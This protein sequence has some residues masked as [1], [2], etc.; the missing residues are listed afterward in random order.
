VTASTD[1]LPAAWRTLLDVASCPACRSPLRGAWCPA[2]GLR[3]DGPRG[4][5]LWQESQEAAAALERRAATLA[6]LVTA[7]DDAARVWAASV[8]PAA[9]QQ[10]PVQEWTIQ[11]APVQQAPVQRAAVRPGGVPAGPGAQGPAGY[12]SVPGPWLGAGSPLPVPFSPSTRRPWRVQTILQVLGAGLLAAASIVFLVFAWDVL[13]LVARAAVVGVGT[14]A[15]LVLAWWL[16]RRGLVQGAEA[17]GGFGVVLVLLDAWAVRRTGLVDGGS[18]GAYA[19]VALLACAAIVAAWGRAA[20]LT[21]GALAGAVLWVAAPLPLLSL[22]DD[23]VS[24]TTV[25]LLP[26]VAA[27]VRVAPF[28]LAAPPPTDRLVRRVLA[29]CAWASWSLATAWAAVVA[30]AWSSQSD[31]RGVAVLAA[32]A[33]VAAAPVVLTR[34]AGVGE[35]GG[36]ALAAGV[37]TG[38]AVCVAGL[39]AAARAG[40]A[41][42]P[43]LAGGG[44]AVAVLAI[45]VCTARASATGPVGAPGPASAPDPTGAASRTPKRWAIVV[46]GWRRGVLAVAAASALV[47]IAL[48]PWQLA[49]LMLQPADPALGGDL[50]MV[51]AAVAVAAV[52]L[53]RAA[54][55]YRWQGVDACAAVLIAAAAV[56]AVAATT[57]L[58]GTLPWGSVLGLAAVTAAACVGEAAARPTARDALRRPGRLDAADLR[59]AA[60]VAAPAAAL[61]ALIDARTDS[62]AVAVSLAVLFGLAVVARGWA[63]APEAAPLS[64]AAAGPLAALAVG[65]GGCAAGMAPA[66]AAV[67]GAVA[68]TGGLIARALLPGAARPERATA[69]GLSA[70]GAATAW[71][72]AAGSAGQSSPWALWTAVAAGLVVVVAWAWAGPGRVAGAPVAAGAVAP[73]LALAVATVHGRLGIPG[74]AGAAALTAAGIGA[75]ALM[76]AGWLGGHR[77]PGGRMA[78]EVGGY[79]TA[80]AAL[81]AAAAVGPDVLALALLV[82]AVATFVVGLAPDRRPLRWVALGALTVASWLT[83][84]VG[85]VAVPEAYLAPT[86]LVVAVVG[87]LRLRHGVRDAPELLL[88]GLAVATLPTALVGAGLPLG[89]LLVD[90]AAVI[91]LVAAVMIGCAAVLGR[92]QAAPVP[93]RAA[94]ML[95]SLAAVLV[96]CGPTR[97]ALLLAATPAQQWWT[98][99][100]PELWAVA[101]AALLAAAA[102]VLV[103]SLATTA[104]AA[105]VAV[106]T[107]SP[108]VVTALAAAPSA[109]AAEPGTP[110][111]VRA[112]VLAAVA[113]LATVLGA[114]LRPRP[115]T[116]APGGPGPEV[117]GTASG[118]S[119]H[120]LGLGLLVGACATAA[121]TR[122]LP[123]APGGLV[124]GALGVLVLTSV[125]LR[126]PRTDTADVL[127]AAAGPVLLVPLVLARDEAWRPV[128]WL[129]L[130]AVLVL[131]GL[132]GVAPGL[133]SGAPTGPGPRLLA[134]TGAALAVLGPWSVAVQEATQADPHGSVEAWALASALAVA[135]AAAAWRHR[136]PSDPTGLDPA[137]APV[138]TTAW[139]VLAI[140]ALALATVPSLIAADSRAVGLVRVLACFTVGAVLATVAERGAR[141]AGPDGTAH[142][143]I[144]ATGVAVVVAA[145]LAWLTRGGGEPAD[146]PVLALGVALLVPGA[147]RARAV[148]YTATW[149]TVSPGLLLALGAP[150]AA[151]LVAPEPWRLLLVVALGVAATVAGAA[152]RWQ[153]PFV[154]GTLALLVVLVVVAAPWS[155]R[156]IAAADGWVWLATGG[157]LLLGLGLTYERRLT[158]AREAVRYVGAMR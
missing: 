26:A 158:Q 1:P 33:L 110:G 134:G 91:T 32:C 101:G 43:W 145:T 80:L 115:T 64:T 41:A 38:A 68:A 156:V 18:T 21:V 3:L 81:L 13:S 49:A 62:W 58:T 23:D 89:S 78:C 153:A 103:R 147:L 109:L 30:V 127:R 102:A 74:D 2:C 10:A 7:R 131:V 72:V 111:S 83:L 84:G 14:V 34:P 94:A 4:Q 137:R 82:L 151:V 12:P 85:H 6:D 15:V 87:A 60:V 150:T 44:I 129:T 120:L 118:W 53:V 51:S 142:R 28:S 25:L 8:A 29:A 77:P 119:R 112:A 61:L 106:A 75:A 88:G 98:A 124:V 95:A 31:L 42:V 126:P 17:V 116:P 155:G 92:R 16:G 113:V 132:V 56:T 86:G 93:T 52:A 63:P 36:W 148:P 22:V 149:A 55:R 50:L 107:A 144:G 79:G 135:V 45:V 48:W 97:R 71:M 65:V 157:A 27:L 39:T 9:V 100:W 66:D 69:V 122:T 125:T 139:A 73:V 141:T 136:P 121:A 143:A 128:L 138:R 133:R 35:P 54:G 114:V 99:P 24:R 130:A 90:R 104:P 108:W 67:L 70:A 5:R 46:E 123:H 105:A 146:V 37:A 140:P 59:L 96:A 117:V 19:A 47:L 57:A 152:L 11:Q 20:R 40:A 154:L 76:L